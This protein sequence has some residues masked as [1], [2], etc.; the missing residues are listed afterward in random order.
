MRDAMI[1]RG[2]NQVRS[3]AYGRRPGG[4]PL[5]VHA[6]KFTFRRSNSSSE[7]CNKSGGTW[8]NF[9]RVA[10]Q[11]KV[12]KMTFGSDGRCQD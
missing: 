2:D 3:Q 12:H 8:V 4:G 6:E 9:R 10:A 1:L 5:C 11:S 7:A